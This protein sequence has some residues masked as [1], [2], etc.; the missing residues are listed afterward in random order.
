VLVAQQWVATSITVSESAIEAAVS[1]A[2][3]LA[4][5]R[6]SAVLLRLHM[7]IPSRDPWSILGTESGQWAAWYD[8]QSG[9][10]VAA[11]GVAWRAGLENGH[12]FISA[13]HE[14]S[15]I[16]KQIIDAGDVRHST[17]LPLFMGGF[18]FATATR[19]EQAAW[20]GWKR[21][22]L[23]V[24]EWS[25]TQ[26]ANGHTVAVLATLIE[27]TDTVARSQQ[28]VKLLDYRH[29]QLHRHSIARGAPARPLIQRPVEQFSSWEARVN[30]VK[31]AIAEER[32]Q[33]VVLARA[34]TFVSSDGHNFCPVQTLTT[35]RRQHP[36]GY[37]FAFADGPAAFV[38]ASPETL[39]RVDSGR[40]ST[41]ALAGTV[42]RG[43]SA[44]EDQQLSNALLQ[45]HKDRGEQSLVTQAIYDALAPLCTE[46]KHSDEP[47]IRRLAQVQHLV[48]EFSGRLHQDTDLLQVVRHLHPTP[49]VGGWPH[50]AAMN[51]LN[52]REPM[53]R[54]WYGGPVGWMD[55]NGNGVFSVAIRSALIHGRR[56]TAFVGAGI[57]AESQA[58]AEWDETELKLETIAAALRG[59]GPIP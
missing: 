31:A 3:D 47:A 29:Q 16:R 14:C 1:R 18:S 49:A 17:H 41:H 11:Q 50:Q 39:A 53:E 8:G 44:L 35:L 58:R 42:A 57:V 36:G 9:D 21:N 30:A 56:A 25:V 34:S 45:S 2:I 37:C 10:C 5:R 59:R 12:P 33:K 22:L 6:K 46:L 43:K 24:P 28:L 13:Q 38:G 54:G 7:S 55:A 23:F 15:R 32:L 26:R 20:T 51:W 4:L 40:V 48:T 19:P 52:E 27:P